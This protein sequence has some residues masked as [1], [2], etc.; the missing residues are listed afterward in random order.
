MDFS[1]VPVLRVMTINT[2]FRPRVEQRWAELAAWIEAEGPD[3]VCLQE[4]RQEDGRDVSG[5]LASSLPGA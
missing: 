2:L 1:G 3:V 4:C 5:W